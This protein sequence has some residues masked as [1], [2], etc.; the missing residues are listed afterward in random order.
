MK[1]D[2]MEWD[3]T[4]W[5]DC[6][7]KPS[8]RPRSPRQRAGSPKRAPPSPRPAVAAAVVAAPPSPAAA[9]APAQPTATA[10]AAAPAPPTAAEQKLSKALKLGTKVA[11]REAES[12]LW[13]RR[14]LRGYVKPAEYL[15]CATTRRY[16]TSCH[17]AS[18][19]AT[20]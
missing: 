19:R 3:G 13:V 2:G 4:E 16:M 1:W 5:G 12:V 20:D 17:I 15:R 18:H 11:H 9:A 14:L 6:D 8:K 7:V 10:T